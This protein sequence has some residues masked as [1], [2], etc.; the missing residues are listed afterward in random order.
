LLQ[1]FLLDYL[2]TF[3]L[4]CLIQYMDIQWLLNPH[5]EQ[6]YKNKHSFTL[7]PLVFFPC[8][9]SVGILCVL[10]SLLFWLVDKLVA[11]TFCPSWVPPRFHFNLPHPTRR[12]TMV[13]Q[14]I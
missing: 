4:S 9:W 10:Q 1:P 12:H 13:T 2:C 14:S 5:S 7:C 11:A 6:G 8:S 3:I